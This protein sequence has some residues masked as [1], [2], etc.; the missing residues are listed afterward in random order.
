M[1]RNKTNRFLRDEQGSVAIM[2]VLGLSQTSETYRQV[3]PCVWSDHAQIE[4]IPIGNQ[5]VYE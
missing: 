1:T 5:R 4:N 3:S 2:V